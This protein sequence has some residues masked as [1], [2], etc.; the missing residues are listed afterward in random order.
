MRLGTGFGLMNDL[1]PLS[2]NPRACFWGGWGGSICVID[3]DAQLS[4][5]YVMN[6]MD[7]ALVGDMRGALIVLATF[8]ALAHLPT[9]L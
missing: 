2:P 6:R 3:L 5:A 1:I 8:G 9:I 7:G 4:V